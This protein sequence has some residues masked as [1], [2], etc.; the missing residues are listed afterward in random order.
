MTTSDKANGVES[1]R[2]VNVADRL[3]LSG[4]E[5]HVVMVGPAE[6]NGTYDA[7][8]TRA[9][10]NNGRWIRQDRQFDYWKLVLW[11]ETPLALSDDEARRIPMPPSIRF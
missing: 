7:A 9:R 4:K 6:H 11:L 10:W 2:W 5:V 8:R 3:P 1:P